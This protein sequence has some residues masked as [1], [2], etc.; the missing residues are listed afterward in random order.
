MVVAA[1][2]LGDPLSSSSGSSGTLPLTSLRD[3]E[4]NLARK[5]YIEAGIFISYNR[6]QWDKFGSRS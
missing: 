5:E 3:Y 2:L 1:L 4:I 6:T